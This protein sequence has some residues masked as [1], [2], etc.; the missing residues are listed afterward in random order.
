VVVP[1]SFLP[2]LLFE[3]DRQGRENHL[4]LQNEE[5]A[6]ERHAAAKRQL[7]SWKRDLVAQQEVARQ[8]FDKE[9]SRWKSVCAAIKDQLSRREKAAEE[10]LRDWQCQLEAKQRIAIQHFNEEMIK[11]NE[12]VAAIKAEATKRREVFQQMIRQIQQIENGW[13]DSHTQFAA[14]FNS[15][16]LHLSTRRDEYA[17]SEQDITIARNDLLKRKELLQKAQFLQGQFIDDAEIRHIG[18]ARKA[19]LLAYNIETAADVEHHRVRKVPGF[20]AKL[21][22]RLV[23]WRESVEKSFVLDS[24]QGIPADE[25][26]ALNMKFFQMRRPLIDELQA[27]ETTL[28]AIRTR[29]EAELRRVIQMV[30]RY[31]QYAAQAYADCNEIPEGTGL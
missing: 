10:Q 20:S 31:L 21:T 18:R 23:L 22:Q 29:A 9:L 16:K 1:L 25:Q 4:N 3:L 8:E 6:R 15:A 5:R 2:W 13:H 14:E 7:Q 30:E 24:A 17:K 12:T 11:W 28:K 26:R 27:G 19:T